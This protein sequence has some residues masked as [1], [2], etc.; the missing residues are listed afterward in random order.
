M[1]AGVLICRSFMLRKKFLY[2]N[3]VCLFVKENIT[4][5]S[6]QMFT[7][8]REDNSVESFT[9]LMQIEFPELGIFGLNVIVILQKIRDY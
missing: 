3:D 6:M 2:R 7:S 9:G 1:K 5:Y 4:W 8:G